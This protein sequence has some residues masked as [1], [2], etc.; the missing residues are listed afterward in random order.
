VV[1][2]YP[3]SR[4]FN[5]MDRNEQISI[6]PI[7]AFWLSLAIVWGAYLAYP[8]SELDEGLIVIGTG[9]SLVAVCATIILIQRRQLR[10]ELRSVRE[11]EQAARQ[12]LWP[13]FK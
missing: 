5:Q 8:R 11:E 4:R 10:R 7:V 2:G 13:G 1:A 6:A 9:L 3:P 12:R